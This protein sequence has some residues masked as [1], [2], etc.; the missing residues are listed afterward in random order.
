[1]SCIAGDGVLKLESKKVVTWDQLET[2]RQ[3]WR[4]DNRVV[5]FTNGVFDIL[6]AG[7]VYY[8]QQARDL[9]DLLIVGLNSDAS[10]RRYKGS[11]R[12]LQSEEDRAFVLAGLESVDY[13]TLFEQDT[14]GELID[15]LIP[16][17]LVKG[18]D[19]TPDDIVGAKTVRS[20]GGTVQVIPFVPGRATSNILDKYVR[21]RDRNFSESP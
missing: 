6:H 12:P 7:H 3:R 14:P 19:Y 2:M 8:L 18:G 16:D 9:G 20:H 5:V 10:V 4:E 21:S 13:V 11:D 17:V 15:R 1:M